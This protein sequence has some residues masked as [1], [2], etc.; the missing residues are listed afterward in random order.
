[1]SWHNPSNAPTGEPF[2]GY[3]ARFF[4][5]ATM[6]LSHL[7][8]DCG[9]ILA[10][11]QHRHEQV[12]NMLEG[13]FELT[14]NGETRILRPGDVAIIPGNTPHSG[15]AITKCRIIDAFHP[16]REDYQERFGAGTGS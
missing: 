2:P 10:E 13:E 1:M 4:H 9:A 12:V 7:E 8:V 3:H 11:H 15:R 6:T 5:S 16:A 14:M